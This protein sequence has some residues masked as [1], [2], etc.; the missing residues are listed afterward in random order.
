MGNTQAKILYFTL[1]TLYR[2]YRLTAESH[3]AESQQPKANSHSLVACDG[4]A[5]KVAPFRPTAIIVAN[6]LVTE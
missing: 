5:N 2:L 6:F 1:A 3:L 4:R